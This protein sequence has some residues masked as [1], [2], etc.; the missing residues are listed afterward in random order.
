MAKRPR[1]LASLGVPHEQYT[2]FYLY[3]TSSAA[4]EIVQ[5]ERNSERRRENPVDP[6]RPLLRIG[7]E[8]SAKDP[9]R[10][11]SFGRKIDG[12]DVLLPKNWSKTDQ[13][14]FDIS[15][16]SG[17]I[18]LMTLPVETVPNSSYRLVIAISTIE[19]CG[20]HFHGKP[21]S[22]QITF[23]ISICKTRNSNYTLIVLQ[24]DH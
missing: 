20:S 16:R 13:C 15:V 17:E 3:P 2:A 4:I 22:Y 9:S 19:R 12:N 8:R 21:L 1:N 5:D 23:I 24:M 14:Y 6:T 18:V 7:L 11:V 10:L